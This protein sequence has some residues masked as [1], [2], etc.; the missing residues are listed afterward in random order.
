MIRRPPRST[1]TDT[2]FPY[3]TLFRSAGADARTAGAYARALVAIGRT[4]ATPQLLDRMAGGRPR[5]HD[6]ARTR[7]FQRL[8]R[9]SPLR[10]LCGPLSRSRADHGGVA[11][12]VEAIAR[13]SA[14]L[15]AWRRAPRGRSEERRVGEECVSTCRLRGATDH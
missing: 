5:R 6:D 10:R 1:R 11:H 13:N 3:T 14:M 15:L 12:P 8:H 7:L 9:P 2:L 4:Q